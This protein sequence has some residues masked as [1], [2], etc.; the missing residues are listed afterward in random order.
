MKKFVFLLFLTSFYFCGA[1]IQIDS[2]NKLIYFEQV[3]EIDGESAILKDKAFEWVAKIFN[4][5]NY[6]IRLNSKDKIIAK[7]TQKVLKT[8]YDLTPIQFDYTLDLSFKDGRYKIELNNII[9]QDV[10]ISLMT[11][12]EY[13]AFATENTIT[14]FKL[15]NVK[16]KL[17]EKELRKMDDEVYFDKISSVYIKTAKENTENIK[18]ELEKINLSL[19]SHM[20]SS[21]KKDDW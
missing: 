11:R 19:L 12:S 8:D 7:G 2:I 5:S 10:S 3:H 6:V 14:A 17:L 9:S 21:T 16:D 20:K 4:N 18:F 1:Q 15:L 13:K